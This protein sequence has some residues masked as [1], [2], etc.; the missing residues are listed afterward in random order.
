MNGISGIFR[1]AVKKRNVLH[2]IR[3]LKLDVLLDH[4]PD[5][6]DSHFLLLLLRIYLAAEGSELLNSELL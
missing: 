4:P 5:L 6:S 1:H 2:L 3:D